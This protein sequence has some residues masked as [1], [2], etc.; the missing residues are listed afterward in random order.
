VISWFQAFA[1]KFNLYR[2]TADPSLAGSADTALRT[3]L[4]TLVEVCMRTKPGT[5]RKHAAALAGLA[6]RAGGGGGGSGSIGTGGGAQAAMAGAAGVTAAGDKVEVAMRLALDALAAATGHATAAEA[7]AAL[8]GELLA[9]LRALPPK[10]W[11]A[12]DAAVLASCA[13]VP[14]TPT[15][16]DA[17]AMVQLAALVAERPVAAAVR[18]R[19]LAFPFVTRLTAPLADGDVMLLLGAALPPAAANPGGAFA[20]PALA[21]AAAA[22]NPAVSSAAAAAAAAAEPTTARC[23]ALILS[24]DAA[25]S[26][27]RA[28]AAALIGTLVSRCRESSSLSPPSSSSSASSAALSTSTSR[29]VARV[30]PALR[31]RLDDANDAVRRAAAAALAS[32]APT[33]PLAAYHATRAVLQPHLLSGDEDGGVMRAAVRAVLEA[34]HGAY[35]AVVA[36]AVERSG[37]KL[38]DHPTVLAGLTGGKWTDAD[39][40]DLDVVGAV[41]VRES[42]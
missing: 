9:P 6:L 8:R 12:T 3:A 20:R 37:L 28:D 30:A 13:E 22:L 31:A 17:A 19:L 34:A 32:L 21:A 25:S 10:G 14:G 26:L 36:A 5:W 42:S 18:A 41:Q 29:L 33:S 7:V 35:P 1:F 27:V 4:C 38:S 11:K 16:A 23:L 2:Y 39:V 24:H 15:Q 40:E